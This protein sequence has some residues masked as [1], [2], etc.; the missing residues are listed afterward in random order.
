MYSAALPARMVHQC[1][2]GRCITPR[3][4][5]AKATCMQIR[6]FSSAYLPNPEYDGGYKLGWDNVK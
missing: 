6:V 4:I 2:R 5:L 3:L 1:R